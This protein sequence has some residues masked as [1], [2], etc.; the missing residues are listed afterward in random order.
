MRSILLVDTSVCCKCAFLFDTKRM[1]NETIMSIDE[2]KLDSMIW[3]DARRPNSDEWFSVLFDNANDAIFIHTPNEEGRAGKFTEVNLVACQTFGY[4]RQEL[5]N[6]SAV[7]LTLKSK[8]DDIPAQRGAFRIGKKVVFETTYVAKDSTQIPVEISTHLFKLNGRSTVIDIVRDITER[9]HVEYQI[10]KTSS[11]MEALVEKRTSDLQYVNEKLEAQIVERQRIEKALMESEESLKDLLEN[12]NDLIQ[13]VDT[14]GRFT[15]VNRSWRET[16]GYKPEEISGLS[17]MDIVHPESRKDCI[18]RFGKLLTG[19]PLTRMEAAFITK[20]GNKVIVNGSANCR[21]VEGKPV[22][23]RAILR[24]ITRRRNIEAELTELYKSEKREREELQ[25]ESKARSNFIKVL[26]HELRTPLTPL[27]ASAGLLEE[28]F[29]FKPKAMEYR[30]SHVLHSG[31]QNLSRR[32]NELLDLARFESGNMNIHA[33]A[34]DPKPSILKVYAEFVVKAAKHE[35]TLLLEMPDRLPTIVADKPRLERVL[36]NLISNAIR[37]SKE[38]EKIHVRV[39]R[40]ENELI[41]DVQHQGEGFSPEEQAR[42]FEAYHRVEQ[43]RQKFP[44]LGLELAISKQIVEAHNGT[45][46]LTSEKENG[47]TFT[48]SLPITEI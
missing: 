6:M 34:C 21:F 32:L 15:Y 23:I 44:G 1:R 36:S 35:Q 25:K 26:A 5:L 40:K 2:L 30:L 39:K 8:I 13:I 29:Q 43:D 18:N 28:M 4:T 3:D 42:I 37:F 46:T 22:A 33:R 31:A 19:E 45:L 47:S 10:Q 7:D 9:K 38:K 24:D 27:I 41:I 48:M 12:A 20:D 17:Y 14:N 16:L 11:V